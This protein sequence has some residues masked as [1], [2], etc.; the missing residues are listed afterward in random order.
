MATRPIFIPIID[1][2]AGV[3]M[4]MLE[5]KWHPGMAVSQKQ[6]SIR[7]L[8]ATALAIN[9]QPVLE[10]SSKSE[11]ELG[12]RLSAF[13]LKVVTKVKH[14][15]FSV[16]SAFQSSKVFER[17]GPYTDL[18]DVDSRQAKKDSR[19]KASGNL[20]GFKFFG[21]E[22]S[23]TPRTSFYDWLYINALQQNLDLA[24]QLINYN[25]F[26]DVEFNPGKSINCQAYSAA[27]YSSLKKK[28]LLS[29]A[30]EEPTTFINILAEEYR[31]KDKFISAQKGFL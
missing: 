16:E 5:F 15:E 31:K 22:Y 6:K 30:L 23:L 9:I 19:L 20:I 29:K 18:L 10:I 1:G 17:G 12:V 27:L 14:R 7:E 4:K 3:T 2:Q 8:H 11:S 13:N 21:K 25:G 26:T 24:D 28:G